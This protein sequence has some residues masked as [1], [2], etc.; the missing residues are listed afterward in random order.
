MELGDK[1]IYYT[2]EQNDAN[3][4]A[5]DQLAFVLRIIDE[6]TAD[7][8]VVPP[9]GPIQ[10]VRAALFDPDYFY[11][12][13]GTSYWRPY[14]EEPPDF[15]SLFIYNADP[16]WSAMIQRQWREYNA[17]RIED[18]DEVQARHEHERSVMEDVMKKRYDVEEAQ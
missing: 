14:G 15:D 8:M 9:G 10:F 5:I 18:R 17:A 2:H 4:S 1:V 3:H 6:R 16:D 11:N 7:L 12:Q 13:V